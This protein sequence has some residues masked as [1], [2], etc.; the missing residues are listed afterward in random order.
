MQPLD[1]AGLQKLPAADYHV[2]LKIDGE[3]NLL[4]YAT[5]QAILVNPG[6]TVCTGLSCLDEAAGQLQQAGNRRFIA[7]MCLA[8]HLRPPQPAHQRGLSNRFRT[9]F[10]YP[11]LIDRI[12]YA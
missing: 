4:V 2:S 1:E 9:Q 3:F 8:A 11:L 12:T 5:S 7:A 10:A 6:G